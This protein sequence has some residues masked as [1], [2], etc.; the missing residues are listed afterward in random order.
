MTTM[1]TIS[2]RYSEIPFAH[3]QPKHKGHCA[4]IHGHNWHFEFEFAATTLDECGF[5]IDFGNLKWLK[6]LLEL[7]DHKC[8]LSE[9]DPLVQ[10]NVFKG[11][12]YI[13]VVVVPDCSCEG[14]ATYLY[15]LV[16]KRVNEET[17]GR[18]WL[19]HVIVFED[20]RNSAKVEFPTQ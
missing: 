3:R 4:W 18:V 17:Q 1:T 11:A 16:S 5:V 14:L 2:K 7:W 13:N 8:L 6:Q 12:E 19:R 20:S 9:D 10:R 15:E